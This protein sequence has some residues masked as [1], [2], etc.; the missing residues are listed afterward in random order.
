MRSKVSNFF[1][2]PKLIEDDLMCAETFVG[3]FEGI[4]GVP[5]TLPLLSP[6]GKI[7]SLPCSLQNKQRCR[8]RRRVAHSL[9]R[10]WT[11]RCPV[12]DSPIGHI[13]ITTEFQNPN[14]KYEHLKRSQQISKKGQNSYFTHQHVKC[15]TFI[16]RSL[17]VV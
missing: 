14:K 9:V 15:V 17:T 10:K 8:R 16:S 1:N 3:I 11:D 12:G 4:E 2:I 6:T 5:L 13:V 7:C